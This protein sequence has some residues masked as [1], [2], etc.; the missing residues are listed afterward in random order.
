MP[1]TITLILPAIT[2]QKILSNEPKHM[3]ATP[4]GDDAANDTTTSVT[5]FAHN[6]SHSAGT[7]VF[8]DDASDANDCIFCFHMI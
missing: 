5:T 8:S 7:D 2:S 4:E 1:L 6:V 3:H